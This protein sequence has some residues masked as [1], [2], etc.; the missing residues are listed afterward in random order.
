[1]SLASSLVT[2]ALGVAG[3]PLFVVIAVGALLSFYLAGI[4]SSAVIIEMYRLADTPILVAIPLFAFAGYILSESGAPKR[5]VR[6]SRAF[7]GWM[8]GGLTLVVL[9]LYTLF[10]AF[11]GASGVAI[12]ALGGLTFPALI[13]QKY[14]ERFSLG[15]ITTTGCPGLLL[16]P[17][18]PLILYGVVSGAEMDKL[19]KAGILPG[20]ILA[21]LL[22][23]YCIVRGWKAGTPT[24]RVST[25][26][27]WEAFL[28]SKW[29]IPLP[30]VVLGGIYTGY[31]AVSD[32]AAITAFY[33]LIVEA[34]IHRE[35]K[36][37]A[38][39]PIIKESMVLVGGI[40]IILGV[41]FAYTNYLIDTKVPMR[42]LAFI[43]G[44]ITSKWVFLILL[45]IFL[46]IV[47]S[48]IDI[49]SALVVVV[50]LILPLAHAYGIDPIH[51]GI[52]F[53]TN[54][55][56]G[57]ATPPVGMNL[58]IASYRFGRPILSLYRA[59]LPFLAILLLGLILITYLPSVSLVLVR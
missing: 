21:I 25:R 3:A 5:L 29:E 38:L 6:V 43:Q 31:F 4:D 22:F 13:S 59:S 50:P 42:F 34:V 53:L 12:I 19:F 23:L 32:A 47:G 11:T 17:S 27:M 46:L 54:L 56:I 7:L 14:P 24:V 33:V 9:G 2:L 41:A 58:F 8:P 10:T 28:E 20:S 40:L 26:E 51:L 18:L 30:L 39:V 35:V 55:G 57:Y 36:V 37:K 49:F 52:I 44:H 45:N 15:L 48:M 16:P 1:M